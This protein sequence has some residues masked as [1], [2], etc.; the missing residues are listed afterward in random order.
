M[1]FSLSL[2]LS[3]HPLS[4]ISINMSS[5]E[6]LK[7][8]SKMQD[9]LMSPNYWGL[10]LTLRVTAAALMIKSFTETLMSSERKTGILKLLLIINFSID[11]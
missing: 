4:L 11:H 7:K 9:Y 3:P 2:F 6:D 8:K 1:S 5:N 10:L